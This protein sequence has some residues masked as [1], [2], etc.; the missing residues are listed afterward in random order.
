VDITVSHPVKMTPQSPGATP[1][2]RCSRGKAI[3]E[4]VKERKRDGSR[5]KDSAL[6]VQTE[7]G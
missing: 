3:E 2:A 5:K 1:R 4:K 7:R 6:N